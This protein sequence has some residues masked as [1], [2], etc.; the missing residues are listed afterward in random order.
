[1][2]PKTQTLVMIATTM[3]ASG[4]IQLQSANSQTFRIN[5]HGKTGHG[6]TTD[7]GSITALHVGGLQ[8]DYIFPQM[9]IGINTASKSD[10]GFKTSDLPPAYFIDR[11]GTRHSVNRIGETGLQTTLNIRFFPGES[12]MPVFARDGTV[13]GV[14][15]GNVFIAKTWLGRMSRVK[16]IVEAAN[17]KND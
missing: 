2:K 14:V 5:N 10:E 15:L 16:P 3:L 12:G 9:D 4:T 17:P 8:F 13:C 11:R 1:M 6:F 7:E